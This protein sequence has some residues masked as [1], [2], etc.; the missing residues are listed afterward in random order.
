ML[1]N[2]NKSQGGFLLLEMCLAMVM[3]MIL[4]SC[5]AVLIWFLVQERAY[6]ESR[7]VEFSPWLQIEVIQHE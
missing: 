3:L 2:W 6:D 7:K 4:A 1:S 5:C